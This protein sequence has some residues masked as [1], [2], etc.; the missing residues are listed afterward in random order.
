EDYQIV[1]NK[2][3]RNFLENLLMFY[4]LSFEQKIQ[5]ENKIH[6]INDSKRHIEKFT[7]RKYDIIDEKVMG[8]F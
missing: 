3:P 7:A 5:L 1:K 4:T 2:R 8:G 6:V